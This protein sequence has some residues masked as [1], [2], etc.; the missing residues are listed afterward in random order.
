MRKD[1]E[2]KRLILSPELQGVTLLSR[3]AR[4]EQEAGIVPASELHTREDRVRQYDLLEGMIG[5]TR[6]LPIHLGNGTTIWRKMESDNPSGSHYDRAA[7]TVLRTLEERDFIKPGDKILEGSSGSAGRSFAYHCNRLGFEL[8]MVVPVES[9]FPQERSQPM[10]D[11]GAN[12]IRAD[13][14]GG[15]ARVIEKFSAMRRDL[16]RDGFKRDRNPELMIEG[17]P[18]IIFN[19]GDQTICAPNHSEIAMTPRAF[20]TIAAEAIEQ[21]PKGVSFDTFIGTLGN[22][23]TMKGITDTLAAHYGR[24]NLTIIGTETTSAPTNAIRKLLGQYGE[25]GVRAAFLEKYGFRMPEL[26]EQTY[27]DSFGASTPGYEPP[28]VEVE[29]IDEIVLLGNEWR[30]FKRR[31]NT[32]ALLNHNVEDTVGNTSAEDLY[33]ALFLGEMYPGRNILVPNYDN[34][35]QYPDYPPEVKEYPYPL[36]PRSDISPYAGKK[37]S[38]NR[39]S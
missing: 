36:A 11:F 29:N 15:I 25:E 3:L 4:R 31:H 12:L 24:D 19:K 38:L 14:T 39:P 27:H 1:H 28:F 35:Q 18:I 34:A 10:V 7:L 13:G 6:L 5:N 9:E 21:L 17:K 30:D 22:G 37:Y 16:M 20:G 32:Y 23:S 33:L 26:H 2:P 8:D